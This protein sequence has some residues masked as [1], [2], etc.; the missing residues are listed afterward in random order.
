MLVELANVMMSH[1][2]AG[3]I[4]RINSGKV[5]NARMIPK[6]TLMFGVPEELQA[7]EVFETKFCKDPMSGGKIISCIASVPES[8]RSL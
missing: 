1:Q 7:E 2:K 8:G 6:A 4:E 5:V 3:G